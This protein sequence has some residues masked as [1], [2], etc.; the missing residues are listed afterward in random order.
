MLSNL[1]D[2]QPTFIRL[3]EEDR[4]KGYLILENFQL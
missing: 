1:I 3:Q 2:N 4:I